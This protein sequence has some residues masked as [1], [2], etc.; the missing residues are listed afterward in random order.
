MNRD[1]SIW[2]FCF[3]R[4]HVPADFFGGCPICT[5]GPAMAQRPRVLVDTGF[6]RGSSMIGRLLEKYRNAARYLA[7]MGYRPE[8]IRK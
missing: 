3:C 2:S 5:A 1:R 8:D 6:E 7:K 4:C